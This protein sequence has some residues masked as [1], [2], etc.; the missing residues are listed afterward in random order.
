[1]YLSDLS[2][3]LSCLFIVCVCVPVPVSVSCLLF[4]CKLQMKV[5][6]THPRISER[7]SCAE[8]VATKDLFPEG[9]GGLGGGGGLASRA[10][11]VGAN[12]VD[13]FMLTG[14]GMAMAANTSLCAEV[15]ATKGLFVEG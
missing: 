12:P 9:G 8:A 14:G 2:I 13:R 6:T 5:I 7:V 3:G 4:E 1:M 11:Q 15:A 10:F